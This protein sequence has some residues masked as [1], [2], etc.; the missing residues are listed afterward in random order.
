MSG[1][2]DARQGAPDRRLA[3]GALVV[4]PVGYGE[5]LRVRAAVLRPDQP[6]EVARVA[7][8]DDPTTIHLGARLDGALVGVASVILDVP[9]QVVVAALAGACDATGR[10]WRIRGVGV[11]PEVQGIGVGRAVMHAAVAGALQ[12]ASIGIYLNAR[13][14]VVGFYERLGFVAT[15]E[16]FEVPGIGRHV[17]MIHLPQ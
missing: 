11:L 17:A 13:A 6:L 16:P 4:G 14:W 1:T 5:L 15:G 8:D 9:S 3:E 12:R 10:V 7:G 2:P